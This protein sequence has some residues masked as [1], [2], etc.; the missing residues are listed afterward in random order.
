MIITI[1]GLHGTGKSTIGKK[2]AES[3]GL[4]YYS[5]GQA[6]RELAK[7][8]GMTLE[9]FTAYVEKNPEYDKKLDEKILHLAEKGDIV[10]DSQLSGFILASK[11]DYKILLTCPL[12]IRVK[13][14]AER[15][16]KSYYLK[17]KETTIRENSEKERFKTLYD[18]DLSD[19]DKIND[20]YDLILE[21]KNLSIDEIVL[22]LLHKIKNH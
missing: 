19:V 21:T 20:T 16:N 10:L 2:I 5:T 6:F 12:E 8:N 18:I 1:S 4:R 13:R 17:L 11:A 15:D 3:L 7:E 14:M 22:T 9:E